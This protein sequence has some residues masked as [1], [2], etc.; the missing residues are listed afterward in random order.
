MLFREVRAGSESA[1]MD[2]NFRLNLEYDGT[3]FK[4]WQVQPGERTVQG[5]LEACLRRLLGKPV[6]TVAAGRTD[7]GVHAYGQV[8]GVAH[9]DNWLFQAFIWNPDNGMT[10][11]GTHPDYPDS[12]GYASVINDSGTIAGHGYVAAVNGS[13]PMIWDSGEGKWSPVAT[14]TDFPYAEFYGLNE[15]DQ[16]VGILWNNDQVEH[17]FIYDESNGIRDLNTLCLRSYD[18]KRAK[19]NEKLECVYFRHVDREEK[20]ELNKK[21]E[22]FDG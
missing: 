6:R 11:L 16:M 4:G 17:A 15:S 1:V 8:V 2:R 3:D 21:S 10:D 9:T 19:L 20:V 22:F 18:G 14:P 12:E 5:E 7:T 13:Y